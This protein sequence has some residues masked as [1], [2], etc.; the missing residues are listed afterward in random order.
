MSPRRPLRPSPSTTAGRWLAG[1]ALAATLA[2]ALAARPEADALRARHDALAP[3]LATNA[4]QRPIVLQ[5][6]ESG[7]NLKGEVF[8]I[9]EHPF[10]TLEAGLRS[11]ERWCDVL[12]LPFNVKQCRAAA[13][14]QKLE[15]AIGRKVDQ[16][17]ADAFKVPFDYRLDAA[18]KDY[19]R[20]Q[21]SADTGP[22][23]TRDYRIVFEAVPLDGR[24]S[25]M[26]MA[27]SYGNGFAAKIAMQGY[28][29]TVGRN[30]IGFSIVDK[31]ANGE[32]VYVGDMRG[33]V[34]RNT[35]RY[36]LAIDAYLDSLAAPPQDRVDRRLR[37]W[38]AATER[39][40]QQLHEISQEEYL[41]MNRREIQRQ[42]AETTQAKAG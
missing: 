6:S 27:Y 32:P 5:S 31:R 36:Y 41:A 42:Q 3:Q 9:V 20:V 25:F 23:G 22:M 24:R 12:I 1:I 8:A 29:G 11:A 7:G 15:M 34:E 26:H 17:V 13:G 30:K 10:T 19:L 2:T 21:L 37:G 18:D 4:F 16:A 28:L 40:P 38:F 39:Y 33:V 14:G 35:M